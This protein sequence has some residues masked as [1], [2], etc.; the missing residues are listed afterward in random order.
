MFEDYVLQQKISVSK[1]LKWRAN[2]KRRLSVMLVDDAEV[3]DGGS[4]APYP[5]GDFHQ[6]FILF[7][8]AVVSA[9]ETQQIQSGHCNKTMFSFSLPE[10]DLLAVK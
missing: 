6:R 1:W 9:L 10:I 4:N 8:D 5:G 2:L 3:A 7:H